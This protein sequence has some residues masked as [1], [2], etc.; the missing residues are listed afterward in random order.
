MTKQEAVQHVKRNLWMRGYRVKLASGLADFDLLVNGQYKLS[1]ML[2]GPVPAMAS[3]DVMVMVQGGKKPAIWYAPVS[4]KQD[5]DAG[6]LNRFDK[7]TK[8]PQEVLL[9]VAGK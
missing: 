4:S 6:S 3:C 5:T 1:V 2:G 8:K 9:K 7:F